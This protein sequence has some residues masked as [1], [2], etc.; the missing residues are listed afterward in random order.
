MSARVWSF[1]CGDF[2]REF[3]EIDFFDI[4]EIEGDSRDKVSYFFLLIMVGVVLL[5]TDKLMM[6]DDGLRGVPTNGCCLY[7]TFNVLGKYGEAGR[8][9]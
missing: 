1:L 4:V 6:I 8:T 5:G 3:C 2:R 7:F 9:V